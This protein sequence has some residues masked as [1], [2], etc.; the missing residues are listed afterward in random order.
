MLRLT[1]IQEV[2][3]DAA[4]SSSRN[5]PPKVMT[6]SSPINPHSIGKSATRIKNPNE[7]IDG[8]MYSPNKD[9]SA[10]LIMLSSQKKSPYSSTRKDS[11]SRLTSNH[12]RASN[13][14]S[15]LGLYSPNLKSPMRS[16]SQSKFFQ[17]KTEILDLRDTRQK[18]IP[19]SDH[20]LGI[21]VTQQMEASREDWVSINGIETR[22]QQSE[23]VK[24]LGAWQF[25][26][27]R[28]KGIEVLYILRI[29]PAR[30]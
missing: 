17:N 29:N 23:D 22:D 14:Q 10:D 11:G 30:S 7:S 12:Q 6:N 27:V 1:A 8:S 5:R 16:T 20:S 13:S 3:D 28:E 2:H 25:E 9:M 19:R 15:S 21:Y 4:V 18:T 26:K 24:K